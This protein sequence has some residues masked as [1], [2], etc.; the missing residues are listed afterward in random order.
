MPV[1]VY[2]QS[3]SPETTVGGKRQQEIQ[4]NQ[5]DRITKVKTSADSEIERRTASLNTAISLVNG[6]K[7]LSDSQKTSF[8]NSINTQISNLNALKTKIDADTDLATLKTDQKS[9]FD[10]Y[11]IYMLYI[12]QTRI[13]V[14]SDRMA[15]T[16]DLMNQVAT[17]IQG[18]INGN[19]TWQGILN[20]AT[21]KLSDATTQETNATNLVSGLAPDQGDD[22]K[23]AANTAALKSA[24]T[25]LQA[26]LTDLQ[27]ARK[28]FQTIIS[29]LKAAN[30][31]TSP[32]PTATP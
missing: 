18:R 12:P 16:I 24:R 20:D 19:T 11:R 1:G 4:Q 10:E 23:M 26:A 22:A 5:Q 30:S 6:L 25:D 29:A 28:D 32:T 9:I 27:N 17:K 21:S 2:A 13:M 31:S 7:K 3:A 15:A 14:A 8:V